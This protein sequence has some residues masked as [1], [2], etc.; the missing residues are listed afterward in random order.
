MLALSLSRRLIGL[1]RLIEADRSAALVRQ[2][3]R[4]LAA[5]SLCFAPL[6]SIQR[7]NAFKPKVKD[8]PER[9]GIRAGARKGLRMG[10][11]RTDW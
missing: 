10:L 6:P 4:D 7:T 2:T 11:L 1:M 9:E 8:R 3:S 5:N